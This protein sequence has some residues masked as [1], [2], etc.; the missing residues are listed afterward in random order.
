MEFT[1]LLLT[2]F[3]LKT[4][5][6]KLYTPQFLNNCSIFVLQACTLKIVYGLANKQS[7]LYLQS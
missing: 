3:Q 5:E 6:D 4:D 7:A 1:K 2:H